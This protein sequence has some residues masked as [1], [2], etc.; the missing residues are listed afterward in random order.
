MSIS[1]LNDTQP[2]LCCS[3]AEYQNCCKPLHDLSTN[4]VTAEQLMRSRYSAFAMQNAKYLVHTWDTNTC[5]E[6][7]DFSKDESQW[8]KLEI[9]DTKKG[10]ANDSKGLVEFKAY[11][12][13]HG[14]QQVLSELSRFVKKSSRWLYLD[15]TVK[16][17]ADVGQQTNLGKNAPCSCGSGKKFKRCCGKA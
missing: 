8:E 1:Q 17:V 16:S 13:L 12:V 6:S 7:I 2:C 5:P 4:A 11:Y 9:I 10:R 15:G 14:K 3:G